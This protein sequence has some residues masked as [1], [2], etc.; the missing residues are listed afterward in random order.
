LILPT[1]LWISF[2]WQREEKASLPEVMHYLDLAGWAPESLPCSVAKN[3]GWEGLI[4][5]ASNPDSSL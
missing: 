4:T 2:L 1:K 5:K 3:A